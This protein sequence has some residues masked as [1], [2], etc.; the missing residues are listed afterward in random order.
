MARITDRLSALE[1]LLLAK[2]APSG[3][4]KLFLI[5]LSRACALD[6]HGEVAKARAAAIASGIELT[7]DAHP[8]PAFDADD[9]GVREYIE[10]QQ[11]LLIAEGAAQIA[12]SEAAQAERRAAEEAAKQPPKPQRQPKPTPTFTPSTFPAFART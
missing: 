12:R 5:K 2:P 11:T 4:A 3:P 9:T 10:C 8:A 6:W 7:A 1:A